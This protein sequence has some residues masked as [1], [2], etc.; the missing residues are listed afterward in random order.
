MRYNRANPVLRMEGR[1]PM[2]PEWS[3]D[4]EVVP[5]VMLFTMAGLFSFILLVYVFAYYW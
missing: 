4:P 1:Y 2:K 3:G 5:T